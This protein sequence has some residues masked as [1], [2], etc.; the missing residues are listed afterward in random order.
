MNIAC[1]YLADV[2]LLWR[3]CFHD[4]NQK[5][6]V[7]LEVKQNTGNSEVSE[8]LSC[9]GRRVAGAWEAPSRDTLRGIL[10]CD[11]KRALD[12]ANARAW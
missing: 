4:K 9:E 2:L 10:R 7:I 3:K 8:A 12:C 11:A 6:T 5:T 1:H